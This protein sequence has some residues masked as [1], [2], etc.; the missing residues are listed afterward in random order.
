M[1]AENLKQYDL[2]FT[3]EG[4]TEHSYIETAVKSILSDRYAGVNFEGL[5]IDEMGG[6][7]HFA[8]FEARGRRLPYSV[9]DLTEE[10]AQ[11]RIYALFHLNTRDY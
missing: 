10:E 7:T 5:V 1:N 2:D 8:Y 9:L 11:G 4:D 6:T 3:F